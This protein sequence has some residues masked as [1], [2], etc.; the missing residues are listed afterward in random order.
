MIT[1]NWHQVSDT[2]QHAEHDGCLLVIDRTPDWSSHPAMTYRYHAS[3]YQGSTRTD[4]G[5]FND[6]A[7][8]R[9]KCADFINS[10]AGDS[11][12]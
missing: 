5:T 6:S 7:K 11:K 12:P 4:L 3:C 9:V 2:R 8:A 10:K 1:L